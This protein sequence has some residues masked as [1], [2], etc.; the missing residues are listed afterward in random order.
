MY[1][2]KS[3]P[4]RYRVMMSDYMRYWCRRTRTMSMA[5]AIWCL[6]TGT[7]NA[8]GIADCRNDMILPDDALVK[9]VFHLRRVR[10]ETRL[11]EANIRLTYASFSLSPFNRF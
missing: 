9:G 11:A 6:Q 10:G 2:E 7:G 3:A 1:T 5:L 8:N 4:F